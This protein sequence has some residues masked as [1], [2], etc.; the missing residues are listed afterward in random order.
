MASIKAW[1]TARVLRATGVYRRSYAGGADFAALQAKALAALADPL[2]R[3]LAGV[4]VDV[5]I[6]DDRPVWTLSP[7]DRAPTATVLYWHGGGYVYPPTPLH[8]A[9]YGAMVRDH[10]WRIVAPRYPLAPP[11]DVEDATNFAFALYHDL[12][13]RDGVPTLIGGDSAGGGLAAALAMAVRN[14]GVA[15]PSGLLLIC[16][17]LD[18]RVNHRDQAAIEPRDGIL[19]IA[20]VRKAGALY[21]GEAGVTDVRVSPLLGD[22][23]GLPPILAFGGGDDILVTDARAL[24]AKLP[25]VNYDERAGLLHDWPLFT[26]SESQSARARMAAFAAAHAAPP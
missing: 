15:L 5:T 21:A 8:Y 2:A 4:D 20:G 1:L 7:T 11:H 14:A 24:K 18:A 22:W 6:F 12:I 3:P 16:P 17:W 19:T 23:V 13:A 9:F 10:G 26:F 25:G